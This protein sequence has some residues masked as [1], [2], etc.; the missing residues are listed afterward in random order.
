MNVIVATKLPRERAR[1]ARVLGGAGHQVQAA[2]SPEQ[3]AGCLR[4][5]TPEVAIL[6]HLDPV[7][8]DPLRGAD[9]HIYVIGALTELSG[10]RVQ[11]GWDLGVDDLMRRAASPE[12]LLGRVAAVDRI[13]GWIDTMGD[14]FSSD[15]PFDVQRLHVVQELGTVLAEEFGGITG[16]SMAYRDHGEPPTLM[17]AAEV[18]LTL[19][20]KSV[21]LVLGVGIAEASVTALSHHLFGEEVGG[22]VMADAMREFANSG[23][24]AFKRAALAEDHAFALGLPHDSMLMSPPEGPAI[25]LHAGPVAV[26]VWIAVRQDKPRRVTAANLAEGMV[27]AQPVRNGAGQLLVAA[28]SVL[29]ERTVTRLVEMVGPTALVEVAHAA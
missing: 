20:E 27:L 3:L 6:C 17:Y 23:G 26:T 8:M 15:A 28:G 11:G 9:R 10:R 21:E 25:E 1:L 5:A 7:W 16:L 22:E 2:E 12:E 4:G 29:T 14:D 18:T 13:R 24:G 19:P